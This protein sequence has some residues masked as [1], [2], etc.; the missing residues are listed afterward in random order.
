MGEA[1]VDNSNPAEIEQIVRLVLARL[2]GAAASAEGGAHDLS[3]GA[4]A[5]ENRQAAGDAQSVVRLSQPVIAR[6]TIARRAAAARAIVVPARAV[7]TPAARDL[8]RERGVEIRRAEAVAEA[9]VRL[10]MGM[11]ECDYQP[12][13]L[14]A[15]LEAQA[16]ATQR[17]AHVGLIEVVDELC[18]HVRLGGAR[19]LLLTGETHAALCLANRV[20]GVRA[21]RA[22]CERGVR[23]AREA[24]GVNLL[25]LDPAGKSLHQIERA[26]VEFCRGAA[27]CPARFGK[28]LE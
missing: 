12:A 19:G 6:E 23:R 16:I 11:A 24:V 21:A 22:G 25:V 14:V 17:L 7:I 10:A 26:V 4:R 3:G 5:A 1:R 20:A 15:R 18:Q 27:S 13:S 8:L 2:N 28:R 9:A